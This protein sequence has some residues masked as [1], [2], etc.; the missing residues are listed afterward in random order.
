MS[1]VLLWFLSACCASLNTFLG[2]QVALKSDLPECGK[3]G[4]LLRHVLQSA[5]SADT[6]HKH[7]DPEQ[8]QALC[9]DCSKV[10]GRHYAVAGKLTTPHKMAIMCNSD[11]CLPGEGWTDSKLTDKPH[12]RS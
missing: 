11:V 2:L 6:S 12:Q 4:S 7:V 9:E 1:T 8:F 10:R 5:V 3:E